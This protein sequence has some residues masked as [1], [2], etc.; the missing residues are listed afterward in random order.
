[1]KSRTES[2]LWMVAGAALLALVAGLVFHFHE[3][4]AQALASKANRA[5]L[6]SR[7]QFAL[8]SA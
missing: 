4:P 5:D 7:M 8:A 6:V 2:L 1:M 3:D